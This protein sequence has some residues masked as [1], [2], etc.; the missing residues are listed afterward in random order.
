[1][2]V[3]GAGTVLGLS[4]DVRGGQLPAGQGHN[5][6]LARRGEV[7]LNAGR[8]HGGSR[9]ATG[10]AALRFSQ[11]KGPAAKLLDYQAGGVP[12]AHV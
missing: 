5:Q 11:I 6:D 8:D 7:L 2:P 4:Y 1:M 12:R 10:R 3:E 9:F